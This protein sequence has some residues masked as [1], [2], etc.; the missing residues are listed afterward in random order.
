MS[1]Q[2]KS[3]LIYATGKIF[4]PFRKQVPVSPFQVRTYWDETEGPHFFHRV[5]TKFYKYWN[6]QI[7]NAAGSKSLASPLHSG[8]PALWEYGFLSL[9]QNFGT[10][11]LPYLNAYLN[12]R[13]PYMSPQWLVTTRITPSLKKKII[14]KNAPLELAQNINPFKNKNKI[15]KMHLTVYCKTRNRDRLADG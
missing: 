5:T 7:R 13:G 3:L 14:W 11:S 12:G 10:T 8:P 6:C 1:G 15:Y 2:L 9:R 4:T